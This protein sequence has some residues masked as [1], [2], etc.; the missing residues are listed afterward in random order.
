[1]I[2]PTRCNRSRIYR[3]KT[4]KLHCLSVSIC[5]LDSFIAVSLEFL[6]NPL[7]L[8]SGNI[9][10]CPTSC[11]VRREI[12]S[13]RIQREWP[14]SQFP[15]GLLFCSFYFQHIASPLGSDLIHLFAGL[16][17]CYIIFGNTLGFTYS[18]YYWYD[19]RSVLASFGVIWVWV[20]L[21]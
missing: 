15:V 7:C 5:R 8:F 21:V 3:F 4:S 12:I 16:D 1:M 11:F 6:H 17:R 20:G 13:T 18:E 9:Y 14:S 10:H 19:G 2:G